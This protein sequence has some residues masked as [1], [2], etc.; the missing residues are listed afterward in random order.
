MEL[1]KDRASQRQE[2]RMLKWI[3]NAKNEETMSMWLNILNQSNFT[4]EIPNII[5]QLIILD[6]VTHDCYELI[7][8]KGY[9]YYYEKSSEYIIEKRVKEKTK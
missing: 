3:F 5:Y 8:N 1:E 2:E 4:Y 9:D 6:W 7:I